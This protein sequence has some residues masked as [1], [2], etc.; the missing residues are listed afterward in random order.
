MTNLKLR[1]DRYKLTRAHL[2]IAHIIELVQELVIINMQYKFEQ[3][4]QKTFEVMCPL[5][6]MKFAM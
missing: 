5:F 1:V 2:T 6:K 3:N 4:T